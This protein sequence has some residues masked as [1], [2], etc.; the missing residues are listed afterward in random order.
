LLGIIFFLEFLG[1][2][3]CV[4]TCL[5]PIHDHID[6]WHEFLVYLVLRI[7]IVLSYTNLLLA[8]VIT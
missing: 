7:L 2:G 8:N 6:L 5:G 4:T 3:I 1:H